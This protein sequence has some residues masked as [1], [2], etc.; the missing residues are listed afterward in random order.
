MDWAEA[1]E[2]RGKV[3]GFFDRVK[4]QIS[5]F[6]RAALLTVGKAEA[7]P[8]PFSELMGTQ[9]AKCVMDVGIGGKARAKAKAIISRFA[10]RASLQPSA[11]R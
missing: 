9:F 4:Q 1:G 2:E 10:P 5:P 11:E 6:A 8:R 3:G 7:D